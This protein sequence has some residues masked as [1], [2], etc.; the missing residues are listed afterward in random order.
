MVIL[1]FDELLPQQLVQA[2]EEIP[3]ARL[4]NRYSSVPQNRLRLRLLVRE[5]G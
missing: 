5:F 1:T 2:S 4:R 3:Y